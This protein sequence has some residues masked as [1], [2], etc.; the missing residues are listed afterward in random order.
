MERQRIIITGAVQGVGFRPTVFRLAEHLGLTGWIRNDTAG[1]VMELQGTGQAIERLLARLQTDDKPRLASIITCRQ[2]PVPVACGEKAFSILASDASGDPRVQVTPDTA[3]CEACLTE[4]RDARDFRHAYPF[5]NCT[6]CGPRYSIVTSVPYDRPNTTMSV[7]AMCE[8]CQQQYDNPADRRFHAQPVA[9]PRCGPV[10]W[11]T[12][13]QG[14]TLE[15]DPGRSITQAAEALKHGKIVAI[16]G[17][18]GF[19]LA[20]DACQEGAVARLRE[21]KHRDHKPFALMASSVAVIKRHC[22]VDADAE[23]VLASAQSPIV[24]LPKKAV[25]VLGPDLASGVAPGVNTLGWMLCYA[26]LHWMLFDQGP[27]VL[28]MTS[29]NVSN[30]PLICDNDLAVS[31][32]GEIAD[33]FVMHNREIHR[34]VDDSIVHMINRNPVL[35]R[36][37]RGYMPAPVYLKQANTSAILAAG[38][39]LKN[40]FC[41]V[42]QDQLLCSEHIGDLADAGVYRHFVQSVDHLKG[43][44]DVDPVVVACDLHPGYYSTQYAQQLKQ[45]RMIQV[46]HHWAHVASCLA[47]HQVDGPVIGLVADGTGYGVDGAVWGCECLIASLDSFQRFGHL[48]YF[49]LPGGD[50]AAREPWRPGLSLLTQAFGPDL[51]G[52]DGLLEQRVGDTEAWDVVRQQLGRGLNCVDTSSLGRVFDAVAWLLGLGST[53]HFDAQLPMALESVVDVSVAG[54]YELGFDTLDEVVLWDVI[55]VI[56]DLVTDIQA[57]CEVP[58]MAAKFHWAWIEGFVA[59]AEI[60]QIRTGLDTVVLSG[61]VFCNRILLTRTIKALTQLGFDVLWNQSFPA[62]DGGIALGQA[63]IAAKKV[64]L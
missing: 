15:A 16:K 9:C 24:L 1:V 10:C 25:K 29:G 57:G 5:I 31:R 54:A 22:E 50:K 46:Q 45:V 38:S 20:V 28:V 37:S 58:V 61:G 41:F 40:T 14:R 47:E 60:A 59:M 43:L 19:H 48:E 63:A 12:D 33:L 51:E 53:N 3:V 30:E 2:Q 62:N 39:D 49:S 36:R 42:K 55:P 13:A 7:F 27:D 11:L 52:L 17:V 8:T 44:F 4:M 6:H 64:T 32:L 56:R 21:R 18:G 35:L 23:V 34:Q 26:P